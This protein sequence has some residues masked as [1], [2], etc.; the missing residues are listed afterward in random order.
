MESRV[1]GVF[2]VVTNPRKTITAV[3]LLGHG[4]NNHTCNQF[5]AKME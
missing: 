4:P 3:L 2:V 5:S 1:L